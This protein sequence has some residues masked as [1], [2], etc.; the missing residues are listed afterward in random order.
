K[1][2]ADLTPA[3]AVLFLEAKDFGSLLGDWN[4]SGEKKAWLAGVNYQVFSRSRLYLRL[5][6]VFTEYSAA[7]GLP[8]D[9]SLL[10]S[11]AGGQ[12]ALAVYDINNLEFLYITR[13]AA[14][15]AMQ[16]ALW[17]ARAKFTARTAAGVAYYLKSDGKRTAVFAIAGDLLL[18]GTREDALTGALALIGGANASTVRT[19]DWFQQAT[20]AGP[21][22]GELRMLLNMDKLTRASAFRT[23][24]IQG[25]RAGLLPFHAA[26]NVVNRTAAELNEQRIL[27]RTEPATP[28]DAS[29]TGALLAYAPNAGLYRVWAQPEPSFAGDLL[30]RK[31][32]LPG[33]SMA[34]SSRRAPSASIEALQV[35]AES[36]LEAR[37][38]GA[39]FDPPG[40]VYK[41]EAVQALVAANR[42]QAVLHLQSSRETPDRVFVAN[43]SVVAVHGSA[44]WDGGRVRDAVR[45][46]VDGLYTTASLGLAWRETRKGND[47]IHQF[48]GLARVAFAIRGRT[49]LLSNSAAYLQSV[50]A[51]AGASGANAAYAAGYRTA[52]ELPNYTRIMRLIEAPQAA[53]GDPN[54]PP[55]FS[56]NLASL[57]RALQRAQSVS[58]TATDDGRQVRQSVVY[59]LAR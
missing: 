5:D 51:G 12:T 15:R 28:P 50:L 34:V 14:A 36:D 33:P 55:F 58:I 52:D 22:G 4:A 31:I 32:L 42:P 47:V 23:Y 11:V 40:P 45:E 26:I 19:E 9:M 2:L 17:N 21:Q 8:P 48:D 53:N 43:D 57:A 16:S 30:T 59:R 1:P 41:A 56:G 13:L 35:G 10:N 29:A 3:G 18:V 27:L 20:S 49:L 7:M 6:Q 37:L 39:P 54:E 24:W 46:A 38:D 44:D 25:N